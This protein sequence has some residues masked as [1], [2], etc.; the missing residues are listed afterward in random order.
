MSA[1]LKSLLTKNSEFNRRV[2]GRVLDSRFG[3]NG[4]LVWSIAAFCIAGTVW[5]SL[6]WFGV[7][8]FTPILFLL[9]MFVAPAL[10]VIALVDMIRSRWAWSRLLA[11][12][13]SSGAVA[14]LIGALY[15]LIYSHNAA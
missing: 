1:L 15:H 6:I 10:V 9:S 12:G 11:F 2:H 5:F 8:W 13:I 7:H 3:A 14:L 4:L